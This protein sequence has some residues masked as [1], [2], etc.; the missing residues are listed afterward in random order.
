MGEVVWSVGGTLTAAPVDSIRI[1]QCLVDSKAFREMTNSLV[2]F[3]N[4]V[5]SP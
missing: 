1:R 5:P 2:P 4:G 3:K